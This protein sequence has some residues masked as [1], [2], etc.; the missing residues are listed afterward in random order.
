MKKVLTI[1]SATQDIF[2]LYEDAETLHLLRK[3]QKKSYLLLEQGIKIDV[4]QLHYATGGGA[5]N[6]AF[7]FK[8]LGLEVAIFCKIGTDKPGQF[9]FEQLNREHINTHAIIQNDSISTAISFIIPTPA[10]DYTALVYRGTQTQLINEDLPLSLLTQINYLYITSLAGKSNELLPSLCQEAKKHKVTVSCNPGLDQITKHTHLLHQSLSSIDILILNHFEA[11]KLMISLLNHVQ[12]AQ[13]NAGG[14]NSHADAQTCGFA[15]QAIGDKKV[16]STST[17]RPKN[18]TRSRFEDKAAHLP[19]L[20]SNFITYN[21]TI[22][23]IESYFKV[24]LEQGPSIV[25]LTNSAEGVYVA[26]KEVVYFHPAIAT[27]LVSTVG[28]GDAFGS[29]FVG[30][31]ALGMPIEQAILFGVLNSSSVL[32][33]MDAKEGLL[34]LEQLE[35][36]AK[37]HQGQLQKFSVKTARG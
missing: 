10:K 36:R 21:D 32:T 22:L 11:Q 20:F 19:Q 7:S 9:I 18:D 14:E 3:R 29:C 30:C 35:Q 33:Y 26:T 6:S 34:T 12:V 31:L 37:L 17:E 5:T 16:S 28:A 2:I 1:G 25:V 27:Q 24:I 8:R 23:G 13:N 15:L 4:Q